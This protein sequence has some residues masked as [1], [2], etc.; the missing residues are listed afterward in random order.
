MDGDP[1]LENGRP[2][3]TDVLWG[4]TRPSVAEPHIDTYHQDTPCSLS[5]FPNRFSCNTFIQ[6]PEIGGDFRVHRHRRDD[7]PFRPGPATPF[8]QYEVRNGDLLIFDSGHFHEVLQ[9]EGSRHRLF[10]HAVALLDPASREYSI[11]A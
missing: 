9:V 11:F 6:R 4:L 10:S 2:Y 1:A 8:A 7:G 5:R 3:H